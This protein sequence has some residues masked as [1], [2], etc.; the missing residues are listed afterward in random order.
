[1]GEL[2]KMISLRQAAKLAHKNERFIKTE[3]I[4][5]GHL[6]AWRRGTEKRPKFFVLP[7]E[8]EPAILAATA[9]TPPTATRAKTSPRVPSS[10]H[11]RVRC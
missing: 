4:D 10:L 8:V 6:R 9:Y 1:M 11:P 2:S 7:D 3:L 5:G